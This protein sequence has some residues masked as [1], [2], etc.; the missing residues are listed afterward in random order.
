MAAAYRAAVRALQA[1]VN[2]LPDTDLSEGLPRAYREF[3]LIVRQLSL[4]CAQLEIAGESWMP[5]SVTNLL[6]DMAVS[7][8]HTLHC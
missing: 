5:E 1:F 3:M 8:F 4:C 2:Q 7:F 6:Q